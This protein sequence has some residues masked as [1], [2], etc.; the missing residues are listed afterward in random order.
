VAWVYA[1]RA[2]SFWFSFCKTVPTET[3]RSRTGVDLH[4]QFQ[5]I[6]VHRQVRHSSRPGAFLISFS[7]IFRRFVG[8]GAQRHAFNLCPSL[9]HNNAYVNATAEVSSSRRLMTRGE[10]RAEARSSQFVN[11]RRGIPM[12]ESLLATQYCESPVAASVEER[13]DPR[14]NAC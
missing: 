1:L 9:H 4:L 11:S 2:A 3:R 12:T 13:I 14:S 6:C 8:G 5:N 10:N 7:G